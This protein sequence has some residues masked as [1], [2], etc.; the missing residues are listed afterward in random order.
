MSDYIKSTD[1]TNIFEYPLLP[2]IYEEPDF[3]Q[4][5]NLKDELKKNAT[6]ISSKLGGDA[7]GHLGLVLSP[8]EYSNISV[9]S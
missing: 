6:K 2:N 7:F 8:S 3:E 4:L 1:Y 9:T 5:K